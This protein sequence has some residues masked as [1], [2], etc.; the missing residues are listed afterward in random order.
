MHSVHQMFLTARSIYV[1]VTN[2]R[3][4]LQDKIEREL[5]YWL[6]LIVNFAPSA[7]IIIAVNKW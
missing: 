6:E 7:P 2:P 3:D 1:L 5:N 4:D